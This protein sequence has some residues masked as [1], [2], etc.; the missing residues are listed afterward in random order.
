MDDWRG[1]IVGAGLQRRVEEDPLLAEV[2]AQALSGIEALL[3]ELGNPYRLEARLT[4]GGEYLIRMRV[5]YRSKGERDLIWDRAAEILERARAGRE[6]HIL[7]GISRLAPE[8]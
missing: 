5:A 3:D 6:V 4:R 8:G 2:L 7:C 1:H